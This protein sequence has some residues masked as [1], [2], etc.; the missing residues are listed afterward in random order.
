MRGF[1]KQFKLFYFILYFTWS[2]VYT[3]V[4]LYM[5]EVVGLSLAQIGLMM[6]VL[7]LI[8]LVFQ[9]VWGGVADFSGRRKN[10]LQTLILMNAALAGIITF[11]TNSFAV[12][13][14]YFLY[15]LFLCGQG[16]LTDSMSIQLVNQTPNSSFGF[17]RVWG[18]VGYAIGAFAVAAVANQLGLKWMFYIASIGYFV[19]WMLTFNFKAVQIPIKKSHFKSDLKTLLKQK[20]YLFV[21]I[22]S[23]FLVGSFFGADQYLGL[24]I[25]SNNIEVSMLGVLTF[26]SVCV[27]VP[28][29]FHSKRLIN[30]Y[31][32]V[33][34]L[35]IMNI[36]AVVR[37]VIL[38]FSSTLLMFAIAG[39]LRG[40]IVGIFVPIFIEI[41]CDITPKAV[42]TSA[43]AIYSAVSSGI[44][45]FVFTLAGGLIADRFGYEALFL[46]YGVIMLLPLVLAIKINKAKGLT[47]D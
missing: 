34:L 42:V 19:S 32:A 31:G 22:Y 45:N 17:I 27:E 38:S 13:L 28:I 6:S 21:L 1:M 15:Q 9:P 12:I 43:V 46:G 7:P 40:M 25:R 35:I 10:V 5:N 33:K 37:M 3:L 44:A 18:S 29:I 47:S 30:K 26:I 41:I 36:I 11:F 20:E 24:F 23:F 4:T 39:L 8:S 2:T 16:P 14:L